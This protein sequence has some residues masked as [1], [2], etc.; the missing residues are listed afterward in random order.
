ML[1]CQE[2]ILSAALQ[3]RYALE[4]VIGRGGSA[5]VYLAN[6]LRHNRSVALKAL[7]PALANVVGAERFRREI[8]ITA[9]LQHPHILP[10][11]DSGAAAETVYLVT[12]L[13]D[14]GSLR[15]RLNQVAAF[16]LDEA[17]RIGREV[18]GALAYAHRQGV[19][20]LDVKPEN[21]LLSDGHAVV[22]DFGIA[23]A[24]CDSCPIEADPGFVFGTPAYMS[25]EQAEGGVLDERSDVYSLACVLYEMLTGSPPVMG[26]SPERVIARCGT[27]VPTGLRR[28]RAGI[29]VSVEDVLARSLA[30]AAEARPATVEEVAEALWARP[31]K[32]PVGLA[33][34]PH[35]APVP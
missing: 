16:P 1:E 11:L 9:R 20:H 15:Q 13:V 21:I 5:V 23:R 35:I 28:A 33:G 29:P 2:E 3:G 17:L 27:A 18:A 24:I 6:D 14:R 19:I 22:S 34:Y 12:P 31:I 32:S 26:S 7:H 4:H 8:E 30:R 10:L 25:P